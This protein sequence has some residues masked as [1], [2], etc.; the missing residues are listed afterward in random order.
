MTAEKQS[1]REFRK[2][3]EEKLFDEYKVTLDLVDIAGGIPANPEMI[4]KWI[5]VRNAELNE[6]ERQRLADATKEELPEIADEIESRSWT[7]FKYDEAGPYIEGRIVKSALKENGNILK[8]ILTSVK[9]RK[10][11][12]KKDGDKPQE[13]DK[14][15]IEAEFEKVKGY[16]AL[17]KKISECVFIVEDKIHL[18]RNGVNVSSDVPVEERP[19][20]AFTPQGHINALK[21]TDVLRDVTINFTVRLAKTGAVTEEALFASLAYIVHNALG[22]DRSQGRGRGKDIDVVRIERI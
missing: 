17:K 14:T 19:V 6:A 3:F 20:H 16:P 12:K 9:K 18:Q 15:E 2:Q 7:R 11:T 1:F 4:K 10:V 8:N 22:T 13:S 5:D 21:R